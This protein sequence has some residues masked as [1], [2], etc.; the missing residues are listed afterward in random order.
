MA[1]K[2]MVTSEGGEFEEIESV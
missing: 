1:H 2:V